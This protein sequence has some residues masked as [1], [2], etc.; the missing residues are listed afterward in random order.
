[1]SPGTIK[2]SFVLPPP[3]Q[4]PEHLAAVEN[5]FAELGLRTRNVA[6]D[7]LCGQGGRG[8]PASVILEA[9][10][11]IELVVAGRRLAD[12]LGYFGGVAGKVVFEAGIALRCSPERAGPDAG[13][14]R[15]PADSPGEAIGAARVR[16]GL[17]PA[18]GAP[19]AAA[20]PFADQRSSARA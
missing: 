7:V 19:P 4:P 10:Q 17:E 16:I 11:R 12:R 18:I 3:D 6:G 8:N 20:L 9:D 5:P 15:P 1:M 2:R 14:G 13:A